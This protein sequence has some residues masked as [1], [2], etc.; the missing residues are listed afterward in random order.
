MQTVPW[1]PSVMSANAQQSCLQ[2][3]LVLKLSSAE[4]SAL[5]LIL[6]V[7]YLSLTITIRIQD[8]EQASKWPLILSAN[9]FSPLTWTHHLEITSVFLDSLTKL[10]IC[11]AESSSALPAVLLWITRTRQLVL[12]PT[13]P[14]AGTIRM[15][16]LTVPGWLG[17]QFLLL[18]FRPCR[19]ATLFKMWIPSAEEV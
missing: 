16:I 15:E 14:C 11:K 18:W 2:E 10:Q 7:S 9:L 5:A 17:T 1:E 4:K 13:L 6:N 3:E 19:A 12:E 8:S